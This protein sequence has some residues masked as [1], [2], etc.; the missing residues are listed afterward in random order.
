[1]F[2]FSRWMVGAKRGLGSAA[3]YAMPSKFGGKW[4]TEIDISVQ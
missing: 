1:M 2:S 4:E 3:Q